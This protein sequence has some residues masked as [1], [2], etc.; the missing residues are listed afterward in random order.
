MNMCTQWTV[1]KRGS[2]ENSREALSAPLGH[3]CRRRCSHGLT[4]KALLTTVTHKLQSFFELDHR[5]L[6]LLSP[7]G[8]KLGSQAESSGHGYSVL[9][10]GPPPV[11]CFVFIVL[12]FMCEDV[13]RPK[14]KAECPPSPLASLSLRQALSQ[15]LQLTARELTPAIL[16]SPP[17]QPSSFLHGSRRSHPSPQASTVDMLMPCDILLALSLSFMTRSL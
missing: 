8:S 2:C 10:T 7:L 12:Y 15:N 17:S 6:I 3:P 9:V 16:L 4:K 11:L 14:K 1:Q 13:W 5:L